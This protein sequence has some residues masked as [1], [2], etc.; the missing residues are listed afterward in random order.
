MVLCLPSEKKNKKT[1]FVYGY[2]TENAKPKQGIN[3]TIFG[4]F[5]I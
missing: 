4:T 3:A 5:V 2:I 1:N